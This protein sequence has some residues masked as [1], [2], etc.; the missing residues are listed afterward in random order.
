MISLDP[1]NRVNQQKKL[2]PFDSQN[3]IFDPQNEVI[4][5]RTSLG[6][7]MKYLDAQNENF[8]AAK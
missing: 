3:D 1:Q 5:K 7:K 6:L 8:R 4:D 2:T